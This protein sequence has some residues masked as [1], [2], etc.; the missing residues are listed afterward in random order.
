MIVFA[1]YIGLYMISMLYVMYKP[2]VA[3]VQRQSWK[4]SICLLKQLLRFGF[5]MHA[6]INP[7]QTR[8]IDPMLGQRRTSVVEDGRTLY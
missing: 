8:D 2:T 6:M 4:G 7:Q 3:V 1:G 5:A